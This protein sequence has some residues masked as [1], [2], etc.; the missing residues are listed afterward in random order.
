M[1]K[2]ARRRT[3]PAKK[4]SKAERRKQLLETAHEIVRD[5]GTDALTLGYLAER[6]CTADRPEI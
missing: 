2:S 3:P 1:K 5:E 4:L 6:R